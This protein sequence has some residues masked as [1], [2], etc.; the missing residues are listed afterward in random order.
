[1]NRVVV[2]VDGTPVGLDA[3][4]VA[5][6]EA[7]RRRCT[8]RI[9]HAQD[10]PPLSPSSAD[11]PR[12]VVEDALAQARK[13]APGLATETCHAPEPAGPYLSRLSGSSVLVVVGSRGLS[14]LTGLL[15]GSVSRYVAAHARCPVLIVPADSDLRQAPE[16]PGTIVVGMS[17]RHP[18]T[19]GVEFALE[20]AALRQVHVRIL[21]A[22]P[23]LSSA[24]RSRVEQ[25]VCECG[26]AHPSVSLSAD[27]VDLPPDEALISASE[28]AGLL[29]LGTRTRD[30]G[31]GSIGHKAIEHAF[32]PVVMIPAPV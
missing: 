2:G 7:V 3:L 12:N 11:D 22:T 21:I 19:A 16:S 17:P 5:I 4:D 29:V 25:I 9:A 1:M 26:A 30:G 23:G 31:L 13:R 32:C 10:A 8:L 14:G 15:A 18:R 28:E 27:E 20:E 24:E 6:D